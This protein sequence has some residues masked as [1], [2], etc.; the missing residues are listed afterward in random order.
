M[1]LLSSFLGMAALLLWANI[2]MAEAKPKLWATSGI[3]W[4][5]DW[6]PDGKQFAVAGDLVG[7]F[8]SQSG[9]KLPS[10]KL[11][12]GKPINHI[13]WH[14][15][16]PILATSGGGENSTMIYDPVLNERIVLPTAEG[17]RGVAWNASG[18]RMATA[19]NR[20]ELQIWTAEGK[21]IRTTRPDKAKGLT[22]VAWSPDDERIVTVGE[23]I[24]LHDHSGNIRKTI[25]HRPKSKGF[26][27]LLSVD[28]H[29]SGEFFVVGDYGNY[30]TGESAALQWWSR[31]GELLRT[32][33]PVR[34]KTEFRNAQWSR[35]GNFLATAS[36]ALRI[37]SRQGELLHE[38]KFP[39]NL[40][41]L[42]WSKDGKQLLTSSQKGRVT[43]WD[44]NAKQVRT[45]LA[46]AQ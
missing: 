15:T 34:S 17:T 36:D 1:Q 32:V 35:D 12:E 27:L 10:A 16:K 24:V 13:R 28:W 18:D 5:V 3:L 22:G 39:E 43:L 21:L 41:G 30:D 40:W 37:W 31:E 33:F 38:G 44:Q 7:I 14:P 26:L 23:F 4:N 2:A 25:P 29:P 45:L 8:Q 9:E 11:E 19:G 46:P 20:G 42:R 6:S